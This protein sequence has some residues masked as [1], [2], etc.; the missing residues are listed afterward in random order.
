[1][2]EGLVFK[3]EKKKQANLQLTSSQLAVEG[4]GEERKEDA[5]SRLFLL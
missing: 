4:E 2:E 3:M 5:C 1:M